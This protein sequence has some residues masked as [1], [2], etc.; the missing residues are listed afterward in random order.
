[1]KC[2]NDFVSIK[3]GF[4]F[5]S[6][7]FT[8]DGSY[9]LITIKNVHD[10]AFIEECQSRI[11]D[12]PPK[13]PEYCHV[14]TGDILLSLTGNIGRVCLAHCQNYLLNQRVAK[15][16]PRVPQNRAFTYFTFRRSGF[17]SRLKMMANGVA[18]QN[19]SPIETGRM[20]HALPQSSLLGK[21]SEL[22]EPLIDQMLSLSL[23]NANLCRTRDLLLPKLVSGEISC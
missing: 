19:L 7:T 5:K 14:K 13:M 22:G 18:Q 1:M 9:S 10:G 12:L 15:L 16:V 4:A 17:Q 11:S 6:G 8:P 23:K 21:F 3:S 2:V 20:E